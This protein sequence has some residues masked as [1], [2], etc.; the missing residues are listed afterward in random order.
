MSEI[1]RWLTLLFTALLL[2]WTILNL[3]KMRKP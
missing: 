2:L 3:L 1:E